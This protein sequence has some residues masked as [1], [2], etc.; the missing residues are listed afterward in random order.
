MQ[1]VIVFFFVVLGALSRNERENFVNLWEV[2]VL[3]QW[4]GGTAKGKRQR[5]QQQ[6][7]RNNGCQA[8][9]AAENNIEAASAASSKW[10]P[11]WQHKKGRARAE[12]R[13]RGEIGRLQL[14]HALL[15]WQKAL[16][17]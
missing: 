15:T 9:A 12:E 17:N 6:Q 2:V 10:L 8:A 1:R 7:R 14:Q 13:E 11:P 4:Q 16:I 3:Q 5:Q